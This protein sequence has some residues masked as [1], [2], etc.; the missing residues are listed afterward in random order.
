MLSMQVIKNDQ[1][2]ASKVILIDGEGNKVGETP[3]ERALEIAEEQDLD[4][5]QVQD[6]D[7][8]ICKLMDYNKKAYKKDRRKNKSKT[9]KTKEFRFTM[10]IAIH[11]IQIK[12]KKIE[13]LLQKGH[14]AKL[15]LNNNK[16]MTFNNEEMKNRLSLILSNIAYDFSKDLK[17]NQKNGIWSVEITP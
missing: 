9:T 11:D 16:R 3:L 6:G 7:M 5:V 1:I 4:L 12:A 8:P 10:N 17:F 2:V 14:R 15:V 13:T